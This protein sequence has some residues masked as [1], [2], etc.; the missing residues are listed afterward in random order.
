MIDPDGLDRHDD[1]PRPHR[2]RRLGDRAA[3]LHDGPAT[4]MSIEPADPLLARNAEIRRRSARGESGVELARSFGLCCDTISKILRRS[5]EYSRAG[6]GRRRRRKAQQA[7][8]RVLRSAGG[9]TRQVSRITGLARTQVQRLARPRP[10][11]GPIEDE[12][13]END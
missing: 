2:W 8:A 11:P 7:L 3:E 12:S 5:G 13:R 10:D 4:P 1:F 6:E 9:S